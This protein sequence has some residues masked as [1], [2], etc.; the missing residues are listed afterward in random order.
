MFPCPSPSA[1]TRRTVCCLNGTIWPVREPFP[2]RLHAQ[3]ARSLRSSA[4][5]AQEAVDAAAERLAYLRGQ[6]READKIAA[7]DE[8]WFLSLAVKSK[9]VNKGKVFVFTAYVRIDTNVAAYEVYDEQGQRVEPR[10]I[11]FA[12]K[13]YLKYKKDGVQI[14]INAEEK[15]TH[16]YTFYA[17]NQ[18]GYRSPDCKSL[19]VTVK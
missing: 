12:N 3:Q 2:S 8:D 16:T 11:V 7:A 5:P 18:D 14:R 1:T 9:K 13:A 10:D 17:V 6:L 19:V 15:G 4:S